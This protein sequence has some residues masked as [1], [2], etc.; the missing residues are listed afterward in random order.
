MGPTFPFSNPSPWYLVTRASPSG[1]QLIVH[2]AVSTAGQHLPGYHLPRSLAGNVSAFVGWR[3]STTLPYH[4][5]PRSNKV[6][7]HSG[8]SFSVETQVWLHVLWRCEHFAIHFTTN[9]CRCLLS[10]AVSRDSE[11]KCGRED[12]AGWVWGFSSNWLKQSILTTC[13]SLLSLAADQR[14]YIF[15]V[16]IFVAPIICSQRQ[17]PLFSLCQIVRSFW[18]FMHPFW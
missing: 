8:L 15:K 17:L 6:P 16:V 2:T 13:S 1:W 12:A 3:E 14:Y 4:T 18:L 10:Q 5:K 9:H 11:W 7:L